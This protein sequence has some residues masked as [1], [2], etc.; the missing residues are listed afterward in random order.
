MTT[1]TQDRD[2]SFVMIYREISGDGLPEPPRIEGVPM[3]DDRRAVE[4]A[5]HRVS[6]FM[7]RKMARHI[8]D[9]PGMPEYDILFEIGDNTPLAEPY[10]IGHRMKT[11]MER[12]LIPK[13]RVSLSGRMTPKGETLSMSYS[14][15]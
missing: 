11:Y 13:G 10:I 4:E 9:N 5:T 8:R 14:V 7:A 15:V 6:S 3:G 2:S 1:A 12:G